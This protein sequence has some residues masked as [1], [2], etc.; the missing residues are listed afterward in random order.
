MP[1]LSPL[2]AARRARI[3]RDSPPTPAQQRVLDFIVS[4]FAREL[5][6]PTY[7]EIA[8]GLAFR[9]PT[10]VQH[11]V[12]ALVRRGWL[13]L[14]PGR[15]RAFRLLRHRVS[16]HVERGEKTTLAP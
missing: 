16:I 8:E 11:H 10:A 1:R 12:E 3:D 9:S 7:A 5:M 6:M 14:R 15:A 13:E 4:Y 2:A